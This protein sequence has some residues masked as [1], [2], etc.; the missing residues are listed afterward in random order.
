[1]F[2]IE[3]SYEYIEVKP[4]YLISKKKAEEIYGLTLDDIKK[5]SLH[6]VKCI[7]F[8]ILMDTVYGMTFRIFL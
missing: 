5:F 6:S 8:R 7:Q 2:R 3:M 1:M 4:K